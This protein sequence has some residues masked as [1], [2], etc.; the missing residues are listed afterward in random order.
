MNRTRALGPRPLLLAC[1]LL[2]AALP[3]SS[4]GQGGYRRLV[5]VGEALLARVEAGMADALPAEVGA[6][7]VRYG[8]GSSFRR[9]G[10]TGGALWS[11][12]GLGG[13]AAAGLGVGAWAAHGGAAASLTT[14]AGGLAVVSGGFAGAVLGGVAVYLLASDYV[15]P[16]SMR[17]KDDCWFLSDE[18]SDLSCF[19]EAGALYTLPLDY[20]FTGRDGERAVG[21]C[22]LFLA[23]DSDRRLLTWE[24]DGCAVNGPWVVEPPFAQDE[25]GGLR[26]GGWTGFLDGAQ[27]HRDV[28]ARGEVGL[29]AR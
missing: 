11:I 12:G 20:G 8:L 4:S 27:G 2:L 21:Q 17:A 13:G 6:E 24:V 18:G 19:L 25:E 15:T 28:V 1:S 3:A 9:G 10:G 26:V 29:G 23:L 22:L 16:A 5:H 14:A 7:D